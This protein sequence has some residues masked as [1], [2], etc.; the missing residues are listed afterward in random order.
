M[1]ISTRTNPSRKQV[2]SNLMT[3]TSLFIPMN[4][5]NSSAPAVVESATDK[6]KP[7]CSVT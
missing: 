4:S 5:V 7:S 3:A 6:E 1:V 2:G